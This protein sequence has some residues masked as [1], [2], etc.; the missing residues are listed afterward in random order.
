MVWNGWVDMKKCFVTVGAVYTDS[1]LKKIFENV[2]Y[3]KLDV[4]VIFYSQN[5]I[6]D[7]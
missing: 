7:G 4:G 2:A 1:L 5:L 6:R 3:N